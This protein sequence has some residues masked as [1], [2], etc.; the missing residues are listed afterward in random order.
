[1]SV[2]QQELSLVA[3]KMTLMIHQEDGY[4]TN[5]LV[6]DPPQSLH[7][8]PGSTIVFCTETGAPLLMYSD[9]DGGVALGVG[10]L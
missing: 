4:G 6:K 10:G 7:S 5:L 8:S 3:T 2:W 9:L 1:M